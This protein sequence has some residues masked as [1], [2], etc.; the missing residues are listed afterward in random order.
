MPSFAHHLGFLAAAP[1]VPVP[2]WAGTLGWGTLLRV[3]DD[4]TFFP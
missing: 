1:P 3:R 2:A 4:R